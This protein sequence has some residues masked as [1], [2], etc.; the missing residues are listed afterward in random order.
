MEIP[1]V[2][3]GA[4]G[5]ALITSVMTLIGLVL[6]KEQKT[7]EFRQAWIDALRNELSNVIAHANAIHGAAAASFANPQDTW[8]VVRE[9]YVGINNATAKI[10]L[11]LNPN[12]KTSKSVLSKI[13]DLER[14]LAPGNAIDHS[15]LDGIEKKLVLES[16]ALLKQE[17]ARVKRGEF[18]YRV[19][20]I[21]AFTVF[22][23][24]VIALGYIF[25][26]AYF[27]K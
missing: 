27:A 26:A 15:L 11:R 7:S 13:E 5:A 17:W 3:M 8:K 24:S 23:G 1:T 25:G 14:Q 18:T 9:D 10:R 22:A 4:I 2:A 6:S 12:E 16:Q 21:M 19:A 20:K